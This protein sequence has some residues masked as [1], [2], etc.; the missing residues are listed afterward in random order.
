M[1]PRT[2]YAK[3]PGGHVAYQVFG[4]GPLDIVFAPDH[5]SNLEIM[6][7][8]PTL[9]RFL[10]RLSS[11]GRVICFDMRGV[12]V[13]DPVPLGALPT[14]EEWM[15]DIRTVVD[16]VGTGR[17]VLYG[18]GTG[19]KMAILFA[20]TYPERSSA[21]ILQDVTARFLRAP[22][23]PFGLPPELVSR[24]MEHIATRWG[25]GELADESAPSMANNPAFRQW[26]ARYERLCMS[27]GAF[28]AMYRCTVIEPD[29]RPVLATVRTPT[30]VISRN[31][32]F[33]RPEHGRYLAQHIPQARYVELPDTDYEFHA[34]DT[35]AIMTEVQ[36]FLTGDRALP[37]DDRVLATVL[38]TDVVG[39]T[40]RAAAMGDR[41]WRDL[42]ERH[43]AL[44][45]RELT[46]FR[47]REVDTAGDGFLA[48]FD[49]PARAVRCALA[50]RDA[51]RGLGIEVRIGLH[52]GECE[53]IGEKIGGIAVHIGARVSGAAGPGEVLV[54]GTLKDLVAGSGLRFVER[55]KHALKG[56]S[57]EWNLFAAA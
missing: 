33:I 23:Y 26:K 41:A 15:N 9:A 34:G 53:R 17:V 51:V 14:I 8:E 52:T 29:L 47:G 57:G 11:M 25:T 45:R 48:T 10:T 18:Y 49:G 19:G 54:S 38:F 40:E 2:Q 6:W 43:H 55:G 1:P 7:E 35:D 31:N 28:A 50:I 5:P 39:S 42:I 37:D 3:G 24:N 22:D 13:S 56:I 36:E 46:R 21:L 4:E 27:P 12:G 16:A 32:R 30:L 20:A 44:V